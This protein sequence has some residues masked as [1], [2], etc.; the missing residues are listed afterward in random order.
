[1]RFVTSILALAAPLFVAAA[2]L[3][4]DGHEANLLVFSAYPLFLFFYFLCSG[5]VFLIVTMSGSG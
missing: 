5:F 2:P 4:R 3:R 1:M